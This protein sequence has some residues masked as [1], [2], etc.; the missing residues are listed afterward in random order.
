[1]KKFLNNPWT[2]GLG[3]AFFSFVLTIIGDMI[4]GIEILSTFIAVLNF[5]VKVWWILLALLIWKIISIIYRKLSIKLPGDRK[6][7]QEKPAFLTYT[8]AKLQ[9][10]DWKWSWKKSYS[11]EYV[12]DE[13]YPLCA[14]CQT[15]IMKGD[16]LDGRWICPRCQA[17]YKGHTPDVEAVE[18]LIKDNAQR[19]LFPKSEEVQ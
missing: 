9:N 13:L 17:I 14:S 5:R 16:Y 7:N 2:I 8:S 1:M 18:L 10:F 12:I 3:T 4:K 19:G 11:G 6:E 15:P